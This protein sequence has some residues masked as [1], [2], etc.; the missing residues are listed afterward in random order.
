M[1]T[2]R[3]VVDDGA[4]VDSAA[5]PETMYKEDSAMTRRVRLWIIGAAATVVTVSL[6]WL[7]TAAQ[8]GIVMT[9]AD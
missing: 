6:V 4:V 2:E 5:F 1:R 3:A 7:A 9:G 8:A